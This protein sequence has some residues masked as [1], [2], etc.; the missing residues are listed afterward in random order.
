MK[1]NIILNQKEGYHY[2][3]DINDDSKT[4][5]ITNEVYEKVNEILKTVNFIIENVSDKEIIQA[6]PVGK[7][8]E[9][10]GLILYDIIS[11]TPIDY[12]I[13]KIKWTIIHSDPNFISPFRK[14]DN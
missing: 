14:V 1:N 2:F 5:C 6:Y 13:N 8:D 4:Y 9:K 12:P 3:D 7:I 10:N 11:E